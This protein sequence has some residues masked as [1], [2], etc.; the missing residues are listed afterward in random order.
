MLAISLVCACSLQSGYSYSTVHVVPGTIRRTTRTN[1]TGLN[2]PVH[3]TVAGISS[4]N[5]SYVLQTLDLIRSVRQAVLNDFCALSLPRSHAS[6]VV[7][8][9]REKTTS[10]T[11][12]ILLV[13]A[14]TRTF[15]LAPLVFFISE[16]FLLVGI[17]S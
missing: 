14:C 5:C 11:F 12:S 7:V 8:S 10:T 3:G 6:R 9:D 1:N 13:L 2:A 15:Q 16:L 17:H 4:T